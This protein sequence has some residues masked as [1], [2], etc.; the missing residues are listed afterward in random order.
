MQPSFLGCLPQVSPEM[1]PSPHTQHSGHHSTE[2]QFSAKQFTEDFGHYGVGRLPRSTHSEM[3]WCWGGKTMTD[4][5]GASRLLSIQMQSAGL[6]S[7]FHWVACFTMKQFPN[8]SLHFSLSC[9]VLH[10]QVLLL[11]L[12]L[13]ELSAARCCLSV[14]AP[15]ARVIKGGLKMD[16]WQ[17]HSY[18]S[19]SFMLWLLLLTKPKVTNRLQV[20]KIH[21][22]REIYEC[23]HTCIC[24][25]ISQLVMHFS[26][27]QKLL[28]CY[29]R[30][31]C[32]S[33]GASK[34]C[35]ESQDPLLVFLLAPS[36][37]QTKKVT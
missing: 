13:L 26:G 33:W 2:I 23:V 22:Y 8:Y 27:V 10:H 17:L 37:T 21:R 32:K 12:H 7:C 36:L 18:F 20:F 34:D 31:I 30:N 15:L 29:V 9:M 5:D 6:I 1:K 14:N 16:L 4:I 28:Q 24:V 11:P 25:Y 35:H 19:T 3:C